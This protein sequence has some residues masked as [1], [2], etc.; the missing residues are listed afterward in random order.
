MSEHEAVSGTGRWSMNKSP[1]LRI[2]RYINER[3]WTGRHQRF[4]V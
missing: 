4:L 2:E 1:N 3:L